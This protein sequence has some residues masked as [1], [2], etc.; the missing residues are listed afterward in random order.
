MF[1][2]VKNV[3]N[4]SFSSVNN[5][6]FFAGIMMLLVNIG[7]RYVTIKFS[8]SQ[9]EYI[10]SKVA[11]EFLIFAIIWMATRD[12]FVS[13]V[14]TASF[15]ILA[16]YLFNENSQFCVL[17]EKF[18]NLQYL[19]DSN[20]DGIISDEE[21]KQAEETLRKAKLQKKKTNQLEMLSY[22]SS[23]SSLSDVATYTTL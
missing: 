8:K 6:K 7:S 21:I 5:S 4:T 18:K 10:K 2:I 16:D 1:E 13:I 11:R 22:L 3:V 15:I 9:E 20:N 14:M 17:P 12:L 23:S 19:I